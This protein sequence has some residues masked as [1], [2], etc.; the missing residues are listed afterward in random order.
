MFLFFAW[1]RP[2]DWT[3]GPSVLN[4]TSNHKTDVVVGFHDAKM[5]LDPRSRFWD[6]TGRCSCC[7]VINIPLGG[8]VAARELL[9]PRQ[10]LTHVAKL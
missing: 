1:E 3:I 4:P 2:I 10:G 6:N 7:V 9:D 5:L 8:Q